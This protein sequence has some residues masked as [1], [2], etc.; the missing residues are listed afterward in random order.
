MRTAFRTPH[1]E[2]T[3]TRMSTVQTMADRTQRPWWLL[4][5]G[6]VGVLILVLAGL[7]LRA[8]VGQEADPP[9]G[10]H[11]VRLSR[12]WRSFYE[13][14]QTWTGYPV[15]AE[16]D[17]EGRRCQPFVNAIVCKQGGER[18]GTLR[19]DYTLVDLGQRALPAELSPHPSPVP[20]ILQA[21][22]TEWERDGVDWR[23]WVGLPITGVF[24]VSGPQGDADATCVVYTPTQRL[25]WPKAQE[26]DPRALTLS[27]LGLHVR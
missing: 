24:C 7:G 8:W 27:P 12:E 3:V 19:E 17:F 26:A 23:F 15:A 5:G 10:P 11:Q 2:E 16:Q 1:R 25:T 9:V 20:S 4:P 14:Y 6:V 21:R 22:I 18:R 13:Q